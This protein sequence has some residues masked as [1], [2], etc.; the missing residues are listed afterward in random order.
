VCLCGVN[1]VVAIIEPARDQS[2]D[3]T[4]RML[5]IAVHEQNS[6]RTSVVEAGEQS[7]F[8]SEISRQRDNLDV[9]GQGGQRFCD[10]AGLIAAS[11]VNVYDLKA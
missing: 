2:V 5:S 8:L 10:A 11:V 9:D 3:Q 1:H 7:G 6:A 4:R